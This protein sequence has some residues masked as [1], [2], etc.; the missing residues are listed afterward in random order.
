[1]TRAK[2]EMPTGSPSSLTVAHFQALPGTKEAKKGLRRQYTTLT[3]RSALLDLAPMLALN[4]DYVIVFWNSASRKLYGFT[5]DEALGRIS[6]ELLRTVYPKPLEEIRAALFAEGSWSGELLRTRRDGALITVASQWVLQ[7]DSAGK[8]LS[9]LETSHDISLL[10]RAQES[11][12]ENEEK[13]RQIVETAIEGI[14]IVNSEGITTFCNTR[15]P[16]MLGL[17]RDRIIGISMFAFVFEEDMGEARRFFELK[18]QG[19]SDTFNMRLK[20]GDGSAMWSTISASPLKNDRGEFVGVLRMVTDIT[21]TKRA[22]QEAISILESL[23]EGYLAFDRE[24]RVTYANSGAERLLGKSRESLIGK[25]QWESCPESAGT[26][27]A[28]QYRRAMTERITVT[29][30]NYYAPWDR[31]YSVTAFP[32][33]NGGLAAYFR[34]VT[35]VRKAEAARRRSEDMLHLAQKAA[36]AAA[37]EWDMVKGATTWSEAIYELFDL[38]KGVQPSYESFLSRVHPED[39]ERVQAETYRF[40]KS[41]DTFQVD[42]RIIRHD[43]VRWIRSTGKKFLDEHSK[44]LRLI[45]ISADITDSKKTEEVIRQRQKL[46]SVGR[47][48]AGI[49]HDFN[50][51]LTGIM[52][53]ASLAM[54]LIYP[55]HPL[56]P[57]LSMIVESSTNAAHLVRQMLKYAGK[58]MPYPEA[59]DLSA[60]VK[61]SS[62]LIR[63]AVPRQAELLFQADSVLPPVEADAGQIQQVLMSLISN[64]AEAGDEEKRFTILIKTGIRQIDERY[65]HDHS[66]T[67]I[68]P[69]RYVYL[70]VLD[71]GRGMDKETLGKIFEPF[72]STKFLGRG[73]GLAAA[74][75]IVRAY[76]GAIQARSKKGKGS[77]F[78]VLLPAIAEPSDR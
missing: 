28:E 26:V 62:P 42:F 40:A 23:D 9:I 3:N 12:R 71:T 41:G 8:P 73:L 48:A 43:G 22:E 61:D 49:A 56:W 32:A 30:E 60:L 24:F 25:T 6:Y 5:R 1:M 53:N 45:G 58:D 27:L 47:L 67:E 35:E 37:W 68:V 13:Y 63:V 75:G 72:F 7:R 4:L 36:K 46:E 69:G 10:K 52:G 50:N 59:L 51:L 16:E 34:D 57:M 64:A 19:Q 38:E 44:P 17:P 29:F 78:E 14:W 2:A 70:K 54:E 31:W 11:L 55:Q 77:V 39:R 66:L 21:S 15:L 65:I 18:K 33:P 74:Q 20:R 76:R